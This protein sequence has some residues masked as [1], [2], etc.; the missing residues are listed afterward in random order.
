[1]ARP[2]IERPPQ[3]RARKPLDRF[4]ASQLVA[5]ILAQ[6]PPAIRAAI[7]QMALAND[8]AIQPE[9]PLS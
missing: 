5:N 6:H 4:K 3:I 2:P 1:M 8:T 9:L 7:V